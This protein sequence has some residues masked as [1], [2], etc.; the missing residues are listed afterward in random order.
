M[1]LLY[2]TQTAQWSIP[3]TA[4]LETV[5][6]LGI[7]LSIRLHVA[8]L[9]L[10]LGM[11]LLLQT[12]ALQITLAHLSWFAWV[13]FCWSQAKVRHR[14]QAENKGIACVLMLLAGLLLLT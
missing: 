4:L 2:N 13:A 11:G 6:K 14:Q 10:N 1:C 8:Y 5:G 9:I 3:V 12:S 7:A